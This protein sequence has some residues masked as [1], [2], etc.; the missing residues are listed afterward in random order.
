M[1]IV[2][3]LKLGLA[4]VACA[5]PLLAANV[6][7]ASQSMPE[8]PDGHPGLGTQRDANELARYLR[9]PS[10]KDAKEIESW[11]ALPG[12]VQVQW[13]EFERRARKREL[14]SVVGKLP[15]EPTLADLFHAWRTASEDLPK[16]LASS[17]PHAQRLAELHVDLRF[18]ALANLH[19]DFLLERR[20]LMSGLAVLHGMNDGYVVLRD[21][22]AQEISARVDLAAARLRSMALDLD[23]LQK[24]GADD[25]GHPTAALVQECLDAAREPVAG[26]RMRRF[27]TLNEKLDQTAD[28][29]SA[30]LFSGRLARDCEP[31]LRRREAAI[32]DA[33]RRA[34]EVRPFLLET[35]E[36]ADPPPEIAEMKKSSRYAYAL[37]LSVEGLAIDPLNAELAYYAGL[38]SDFTQGPRTTRPWFD[39]F[40]AIRGI[41]EHDPKRLEREMD[42]WERHALDE[43]QDAGPTGLPR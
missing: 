33:E 1:S 30:T 37:R 21:E 34:K 9:K 42:D 8:A 7:V 24:A 38:A 6:C 17:E 19:E 5:L 39:R 16:A 43:V 12:R 3:R 4:R 15:Q 35:K 41:R 32:Q 10:A 11:S 14:F 40:L 26:A 23:T 31:A 18:R 2:A 22:E 13:N 27:A 25:P 36:G 29:L 20:E 28:R